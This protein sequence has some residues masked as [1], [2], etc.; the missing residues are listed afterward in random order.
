MA[1][2]VFP[3]RLISLTKTRLTTVKCCVKIQQLLAYTDE[4]DIVGRS[5]KAVCNAYLALEA[6]ATKVG[7][8]ISEQ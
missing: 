2:L 6:K 5:L 7:L 1:E 8:Q 3:T 4:I